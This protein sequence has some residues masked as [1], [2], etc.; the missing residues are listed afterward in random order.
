[1]N[2]G[3]PF[4]PDPQAS[5]TGQ[6][7]VCGFSGRRCGCPKGRLIVGIASS[8]AFCRHEPAVQ[9]A[10]RPADLFFDAQVVEQQAVRVATAARLCPRTR[11]SPVACSCS[12][13]VKLRATP[14]DLKD[15]LNTTASYSGA[16]CLKPKELFGDCV[17][18]SAEHPPSADLG[19]GAAKSRPSRTM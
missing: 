19:P 13:Y 9:T 7:L 4:V 1:M 6:P 16:A 2:V 14:G 18:G 15:V 12:R 10:P 3:P 5:E 11:R 8:I 17:V